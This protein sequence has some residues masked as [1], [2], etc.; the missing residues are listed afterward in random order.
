MKKN[1][2]VEKLQGL[3]WRNAIYK[4]ESETKKDYSGSISH[5]ID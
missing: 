4:R 2:I 5:S 3:L 1:K